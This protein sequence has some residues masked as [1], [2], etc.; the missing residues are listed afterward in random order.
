MPAMFL[1]DGL[2]TAEVELP[3]LTRLGRAEGGV[4]DVVVD[5]GA[6]GLIE[7][8]DAVGGHEEDAGVVVQD[9]EED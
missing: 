3:D 4:E 1:V 5:A 6:E 8:A 9:A 7:S 2:Q